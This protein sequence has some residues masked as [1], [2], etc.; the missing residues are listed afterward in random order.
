MSVIV[1]PS[2]SVVTV[3]YSL[4]AITATS[5][6]NPQRLGGR[7]IEPL[8]VPEFSGS[9]TGVRVGSACAT[10]VGISAAAV[11]IGSVIASSVRFMTRLLSVPSV[12]V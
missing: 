8:G 10:A 2:A 7:V 9:V 11:M 5:I 6:G 1:V 4:L 3:W 12:V